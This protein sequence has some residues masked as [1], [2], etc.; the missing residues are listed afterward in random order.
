MYILCVS[1]IILFGIYVVI[2]FVKEKNDKLGERWVINL[3]LRVLK[4]WFVVCYFLMLFFWGDI[5][6]DRCIMRI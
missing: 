1:K 2:V 6:M 5:C 4:C 3:K